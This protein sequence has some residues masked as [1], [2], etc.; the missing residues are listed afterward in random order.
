MAAAAGQR[1]ERQTTLHRHWDAPVL[2]GTV[3]QL[4]MLVPSPAKCL[5]ICG[6]AARMLNTCGNGHK[7]HIQLRVNDRISTAGVQ[8]GNRQY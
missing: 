2:I 7:S 3:S 5:T 4:T 8:H 1:L 6:Q